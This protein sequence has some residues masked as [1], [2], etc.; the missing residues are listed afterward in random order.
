M[1]KNEFNK[2]YQDLLDLTKRDF[3]EDVPV[4]NEKKEAFEYVARDTNSYT[5]GWLFDVQKKFNAFLYKHE[6]KFTKPQ[7]DEL[8]T[9]KKQY[10]AMC[11]EL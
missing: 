8:S 7:K 4:W 10:M 11:I 2:D 9:I 6:D 5:L 1:Q 3:T